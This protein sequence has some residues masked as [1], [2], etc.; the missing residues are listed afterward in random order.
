MADLARYL[1]RNDL[2]RRNAAAFVSQLACDDTRPLEVVVRPHKKRRSNS[3]NSYLWGVC[4]PVIMQHLEGW[5]AVD[6]HEFFLGQ[7][8]GWETLQGLGHTKIKPLR[9]SSKLTTLEFMDFVA[10]IQEFMAQRGVVIPDPDP[11]HEDARWRAS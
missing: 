4:Y 2:V 5:T 9:R 6:V 11:T 10:F 3:Q 1:I 8:Y 7:C